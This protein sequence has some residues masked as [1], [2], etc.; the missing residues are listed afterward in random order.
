MKIKN[1]ALIFFVTFMM[2]FIM[3]MLFY[4]C[5]ANMNIKII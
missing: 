2:L 1:I 3:G 5:T 4:G